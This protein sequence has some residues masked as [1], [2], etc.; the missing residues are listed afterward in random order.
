MMSKV[1]EIINIGNKHRNNHNN[2]ISL[3]HCSRQK[4]SDL[5]L[6]IKTYGSNM[7]CIKDIYNNFA[8]LQIQEMPG[9]RYR[10]GYNPP[11]KEG[12]LDE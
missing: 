8:T 1:I 4:N 11:L 6:R 2:R 12:I 5:N 3:V 10:N 9:F 7:N